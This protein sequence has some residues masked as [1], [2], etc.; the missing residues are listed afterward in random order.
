MPARSRTA[1]SPLAHGYQP[2]MIAI[3]GLCVAAALVT[4]VFV[5]DDRMAGPHP[6]AASANPWL[7]P[8]RLEL[9][10]RFVTGRRHHPSEES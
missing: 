4:G 7:C 6:R 8:T 9:G 10:G 2:A 5:S 1:T 3:G